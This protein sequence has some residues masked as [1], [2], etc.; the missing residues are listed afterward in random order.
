MPYAMIVPGRGH[1]SWWAAPIALLLGA[2]LCYSVNLGHLPHPDELH[3][4]LAAKGLLETGEPRIAEGVYTR[5]LL[6]TWLVAQSFALFG[7][8]LSVAR[9][10]ALIPMAVLVALMFV[11]LRRVADERAAW[12][13]TLLF[14]LSPFAVDIAQFSRFYALQMLS[15]FVAAVCAYEVVRPESPGWRRAGLALA[16]AVAAALAFYLQPTTILGLGGLG[17]WLSGAVLLPFFLDPALPRRRKLALAGAL[18]GLVVLGLGVIAATGILDDL[19]SQ[20]RWTPL[21]NRS[22]E[23]QF[24]YYHAW[25]SLLYPSLWPA[26]GVLALAAL[27]AKPR[28]A[29]F[30]AAVFAVGFLLNSFAAAKNLRYMA[31]AQPFLFALWG[32]GL[33]A[34]WDPLGRFLRRLAVDARA[35]LPRSWPVGPGVARATVVAAVVFLLLANP[36]WLRTATLLAGVTIPPDQPPTDWPAARA[37]LEPWLA[38]AGVVVTTEELGALYFLGRYDVRYSPSKLTELAP[39]QRHE[40]GI[41]H[42]TGRPV[43]ATAAS[44]ER[45]IDCYDSGLVVG[46]AEDWGKPHKI[47]GNLARLIAERAEP[48]ELPPRSRLFAYAWERPAGDALPPTCADLPTI[49]TAPRS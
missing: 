25:Y 39:S 14:A 10:P 47:D 49:A 30:V 32:I 4:V 16:A 43:I 31:Y 15:L 6:Y 18:A 35:A 34:L 3:H 12:I 42:R 48:V 46:P 26:T 23:D 29:G 5:T 21:F 8:S 41:D 2:V 1:A 9:L 20:Y 11:W 13:G 45:L 40:F 17:L 44:L 19:W 24:W 7:E 27:A 33:A 36:A 37:A 22:T 28:P 38:R